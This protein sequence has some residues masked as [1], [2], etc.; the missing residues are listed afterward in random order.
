M[1]LDYER[2]RLQ[3][4]LMMQLAGTTASRPQALLDLTYGDVSI[5]LLRDPSGGDRPRVFVELTFNHTKQYLGPKDAYVILP[6][7][8]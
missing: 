2:L 8:T 1:G 5:S 4:A 3:L 7:A 6:S